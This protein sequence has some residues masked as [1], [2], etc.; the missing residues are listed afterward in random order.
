MKAEIKENFSSFDASC[1]AVIPT[2]LHPI[3]VS[4][5]FDAY[6][7]FAAER[8]KVFRQRLERRPEPWTDDPIISV[9]KFTNA[10]R[11]SDRVSQY[12]IRNVIYRDDL[13][14]SPD[15]VLFRTLLFKIFNKIETWRLLEHTFGEITFKSYKF[16][17]YD[18]VLKEAMRAGG[19]IYSAAYIMPPGGSTFG[20]PAKHQNHLRLLE[21]MM[22][23][24]LADQLS[25][26]NCMQAAFELLK[27]YPTIGDF[28][29]YQFVTDINYSEVTNFS[30]MDFVI[31][32]PG[33]RDGVQKCFKD[34]AGLND[35]QLILLMAE[36]QEK[37]F[38]R[39]GIK[40]ESL[41]GRRLQLIDCQNLFCEVDK[42]ARVAHPE[43]EGISGRTRIKQKFHPTGTLERPWY[44]PKWGI[45]SKIDA[46]PFY[47]SETGD[48]DNN[49]R[50][51]FFPLMKSR[52]GE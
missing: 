36:N 20:Y 47:L 48:A 40:F 27:S 41:W 46:D 35:S 15:E 1:A 22:A 33:A 16:E 18:Q 24:N 34:R 39:L 13:P 6:W 52:G 51:D 29:A 50:T 38:E 7:Q 31:P 4:P 45:N 26:Q 10:Y 5:V 25:R 14:S 3:K 17:H 49:F 32:G 2:H 28:L 21:R 19:R 8:Q 23:D 9:H 42:Y 11:A 12:L 44:P 37:E 43:I 30:E